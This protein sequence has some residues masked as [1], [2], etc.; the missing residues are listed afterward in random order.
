MLK[1]LLDACVGAIGFW[2]VGYGISYGNKDNTDEVTFIG[3]EVRRP[4]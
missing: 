1:N 2:A 3:D 4:H